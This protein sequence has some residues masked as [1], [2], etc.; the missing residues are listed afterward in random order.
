MLVQWIV[1]TY[2]LIYK[3]YRRFQHYLQKLTTGESFFIIFLASIILPVI[4]CLEIL[5]EIEN[6]TRHA[7][8][9]LFQK[10][11]NLAWTLMCNPKSCQEHIPAVKRN[12]R[13]IEYG[14]AFCQSFKEF[15]EELF[16]EMIM[17]AHEKVGFR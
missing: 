1:L 16:A 9:R 3:L 4:T 10:S 12:E 14:H 11:M 7:I 17:K 2:Y 15:K 5:C 6:L 13:F 8:P